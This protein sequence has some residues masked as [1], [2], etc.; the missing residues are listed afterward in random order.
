MINSFGMLLMQLAIAGL[1]VWVAYKDIKAAKPEKRQKAIL[2]YTSV[3]V[4]AILLFV[5]LKTFGQDSMD[6]LFYSLG[7]TLN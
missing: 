1:V 6:K 4:G 7:G 5:C 3:L 2:I